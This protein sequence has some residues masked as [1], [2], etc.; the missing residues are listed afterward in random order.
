MVGKEYRGISEF[1]KNMEMFIYLF[2][3]YIWIDG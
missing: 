2:D 3:K 1:L